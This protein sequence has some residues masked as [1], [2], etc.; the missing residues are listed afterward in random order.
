[1]Q[2]EVA[3]WPPCIPSIL[4]PQNYNLIQFFVGPFEN[5]LMHTAIAWAITS[6]NRAKPQRTYIIIGLIAKFT[7]KMFTE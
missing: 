7:V 3:A 2:N 4:Y 5:I 1:M 6:T